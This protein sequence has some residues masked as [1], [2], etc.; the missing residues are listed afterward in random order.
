MRF[1]G[2]RLDRKGFPP[3]STSPSCRVTRSPRRLGEACGKRNSDFGPTAG[4]GSQL[5]SAYTCCDRAML[6]VPPVAPVTRPQP[7]SQGTDESS[8]LSPAKLQTHEQNK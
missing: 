6:E 7:T 5:P 4:I 2:S 3:C 1:E 8:M